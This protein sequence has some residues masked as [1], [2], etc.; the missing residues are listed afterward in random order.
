MRKKLIER[1][2]QSAE[3]LGIAVC[4][5]DEARPYGTEPYCASSWQ[6]KGKPVPYSNDYFREGTVKMLTLFHPN[7]GEVRVKGVTN[8]R[9]DTLHP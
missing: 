6:C 3:D 9:N 7:T 1:A 8:A 4:C 5:E 2:Y